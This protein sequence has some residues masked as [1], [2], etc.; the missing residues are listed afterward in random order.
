MT[1][2]PATMQRV[3][4]AADVAKICGVHRSTVR[5]VM[6]DDPR[7][8]A[9]TAQLVW[10]AA[11]QIGYDPTQHVAARR[12]ALQKQ[13]QVIR[14]YVIG[15]VFPV[16]FQRNNYFNAIHRGI[17]D[18]LE[19]EKFAL[20]TSCYHQPDP[21]LG[22][23]P[24]PPAL[25]RGE[26]DGLIV[27]HTRM[28]GSFLTGL[29]HAGT[30]QQRPTVTLLHTLPSLPAVL[31]DDCAGAY[32][33]AMHLLQLGHRHI[34]QL[35]ISS[36][37]ENMQRRL[38]GIRKAMSETG[39]NPDTHLHQCEVDLNWTMPTT[40]A[41][42]I[43]EQS[44]GKLAHDQS[45]QRLISMLHAHPEITAIM[46]VNDVSA[47]RV[48]H[49]LALEGWRVPD[50]YSLVGFDDTDAQ[51]DAFNRNILTSV[52]LPLEQAGMRVARLILDLIN[53]QAASATPI[54]LQPNLVIRHTTGPC[55]QMKS[56]SSRL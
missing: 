44:V 5:R 49:C 50:D 9:K 1:D 11:R 55:R 35:T 56:V 20:L 12:M 41:E 39:L 43:G 14:N 8:S 37:D 45:K 3:V 36:S 26:V 42:D 54:M 15:C 38:A 7:I 28:F 19:N 21:E 10:E 6:C 51:L 17:F 32:A 33:A 24:I 13:G 31:T 2:K 16:H 53:G 47:T 46:G 29:Q 25:M 40:L 27:L 48:W 18:T 52:S 30:F 34:V 23:S 4:T 22:N